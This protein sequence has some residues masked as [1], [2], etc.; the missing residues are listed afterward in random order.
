M[1]F[2]AKI[3][4]EIL[5]NRNEQGNKQ[6]EEQVNGYEMWIEEETFHSQYQ[7]RMTH[8]QNKK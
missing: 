5:R 3:K 1:I 8:C 7:N 2:E 4:E 6:S